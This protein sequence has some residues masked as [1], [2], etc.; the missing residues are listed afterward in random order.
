M[1]LDETMRQLESM[2]TAQNR[3]VYARHGAGGNMFG[4]SFANLYKLQKTIRT[5]HA[6][7]GQLWETGYTDARIL[8]TLI[9]DPQQ[10]TSRELDRWAKQ[11]NCYG[12]ADM[13]ARYVSRSPL[14]PKKRSQWMHSNDEHVAQA[15]WDLFGI[16]SMKND[17]TLAEEEM[18]EH[19]Q[20]IETHIHQSKN[21]VRYAMNMALIAIGLRNPALRGKALAAAARIG[22]VEVDHGE[23]GCKTPDAVA[24]IRKA[25]SRRRK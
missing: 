2:G 22:K 1:T 6:L 10:A 12:L 23:T 17:E 20:H 21:R 16:A 7:A 4:V 13:F 15:G 14:A 11:I 18:L 19:L 24:Y 8:A 3:K 9:A 25:A 5:D